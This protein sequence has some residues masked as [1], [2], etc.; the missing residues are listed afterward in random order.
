[1]ILSLDQ[2]RWDYKV[3]YR[4]NWE[5]AKKLDVLIESTKVEISFENEVAQASKRIKLNSILKSAEITIRTLQRWKKVYHRNGWVGLLPKKRGG[6]AAV[7]LSAEV[8]THIEHYRSTYRWGSEVIQAHLLRDKEILTTRY[9]IERYLNLSGL[10]LKYPCSTIKKQR[11]QKKKHLKKVVVN[12]PGEHTQMDV[13]YQTHLLLNKEK[14]YVYNFVDHASNWSFKKAYANITAKNTEKFMEELLLECPFIIKRL[15]TDNGIEFTFKWTS[16]NADDPK[17]H[18]LL[19]FCARENIRHVLIPPGEKELQGLVERSHR[20]DDQELFSRISPF[21]LT[22]FNDLLKGY[23]KFRN[24]GRR[25]KKLG[26]ES[27][28]RWLEEYLVRFY[29]VILY[30][31]EKNQDVEKLVA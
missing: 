29:G 10:K 24:R 17:E 18:P 14:A 8:K 25:F 5:V 1:M 27:P 12:H 20:Q 2:L 11:A 26:W 15:Q 30:L 19:K 31:K 9:K 21:D 16:K 4:S 3:L 6:I 28:D 13:K 22:E 7:D 23:W